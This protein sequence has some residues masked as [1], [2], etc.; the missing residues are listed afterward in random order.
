[1]DEHRNNEST[2]DFGNRMQRIDE[3]IQDLELQARRT[4]DDI[5]RLRRQARL[6]VED[7]DGI[8]QD[9]ELSSRRIL[10]A[11][12][13]LPVPASRPRRRCRS[14]S[15]SRARAQGLTS[16]PRKKMKVP[17]PCRNCDEFGHELAECEKAC[18]A[19]GGEGHNFISCSSA[20]TCVCS[21]VPFHNMAECQQICEY[22]SM[23]G[24]NNPVHLVAECPTVCHYCLETD[25]C[26]EDCKAP[27]ESDRRCK[28]CLENGDDKQYHYP[29]SCPRQQSLKSLPET[30][31]GGKGKGTA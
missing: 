17:M 11:Q 29:T 26:T 24:R 14:L 10:P 2:N 23:I 20:D 7:N 31:G 12:T 3:E 15:H 9:Q 27:I 30:K 21:S 8:M 25:H 19:C 16:F 28:A 13:H 18:G 22:C 5:R 6:A 4:D 1:M